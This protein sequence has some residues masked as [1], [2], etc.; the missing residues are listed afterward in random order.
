MTR[1]ALPVVFFDLGDTLVTSPRRWLPGAQGLL[2]RLKASGARLG[3]LSNTTGLASREAILKLL[4]ADFDLSL[5]E[6]DLVL[7]SSEVG[8]AKP[9]AAIYREAVARAKRP[10]GEC[11][12]CSENI[13]E[14]LMAQK[15]GMRAIRVQSPPNS[16]LEGL[17]QAIEEFR[18]LP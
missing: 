1:A 11:F 10:A 3:I 18:A 17:V 9:H 16:D 13:V 8:S 12:Y 4:P 5:F 2:A 7:F 14:T 6:P 15:V